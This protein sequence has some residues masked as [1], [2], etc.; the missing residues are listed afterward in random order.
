MRGGGRGGERRVRVEKLA[1]FAAGFRAMGEAGA[2]A[3]SRT[4]RLLAVAQGGVE[5]ADVV[6]VVDLGRDVLGL[7][8]RTTEAS[9]GGPTV[10][11]TMTPRPPTRPDAGRE[12]A[13]LDLVPRRTAAGALGAATARVAA[14]CADIVPNPTGGRED[15]AAAFLPR[16]G[17]CNATRATVASRFSPKHASRSSPARGRDLQRPMRRD[18][19]NRRFWVRDARRDRRHPI[20]ISFHRPRGEIHRN[21]G[22]KRGFE[23]RRDD[24]RS[25]GGAGW[26]AVFTRSRARRRST[27]RADGFSSI[28]KD[29]LLP[30]SERKKRTPRFPVPRGTVPPCRITWAAC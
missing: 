17:E 16:R 12:T 23:T 30:C 6:G 13:A 7:G 11:A 15:R 14:H 24:T 5:D 4:G 10:A 25:G 20:P 9:S 26:W 1:D 2:R 18:A 3:R 27:T 21:I 29:N 19:S 28:N 8:S 22:R